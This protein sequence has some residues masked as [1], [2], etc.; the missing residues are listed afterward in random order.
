MKC[1]E[2]IS[3]F[4][5]YLD[6]SLN[7][8]QMHSLADHFKTCVKCNA[9]YSSL[10]QTQ[11]LLAGLG[12]KTPPADLA[13]RI[14]VAISQQN[15]ARFS[16]RLQGFLVRLENSV[17]AFMLP[18]GAGLV[19]ATVMFGVLIGFLAVPNKVSANDVPT[20]LYMPPRL[21][22]APF[23]GSLTIDSASPVVIEAYVDS[24][25]RV[26]DYRIIA[27]E[28]TQEVRKQLDRSLIFTVFE[29]AMS[30]GQPATGKVVITF[31][32]VDVK[33]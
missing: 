20:S 18:A 6:G 28:D 24:N 30:F 27:G 32:N 12:H 3:L 1:T 33:G 8:S 31:S 5:P 11:N 19:T 2:A 15:S 10:K 17:N 23:V 14:R 29:P 4:N 9:E 22:S 21:T 25:G 13:L 16:R 7:G 26:A